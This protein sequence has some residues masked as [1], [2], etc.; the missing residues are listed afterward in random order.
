MCFT[1]G[2]KKSIRHM[3]FSISSSN[4]S[5]PGAG[6]PGSSAEDGFDAR[7]T[8][9]PHRAPSYFA[10]ELISSSVTKTHSNSERKHSRSYST[11]SMSEEVTGPDKK[12]R[13]SMSSSVG[14][15]HQKSSSGSTGRG[16]SHSTVSAAEGYSYFFK[17]NNIS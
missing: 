10:D 3:S 1:A 6:T 17:A 11:V 5:F 4:A 8:T 2:L 13:R 14:D 12:R 7:M 16:R 9:R 15:F